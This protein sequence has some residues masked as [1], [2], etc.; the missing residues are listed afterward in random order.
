MTRQTKRGAVLGGR[1]CP[2]ATSTCCVHYTSL[3]NAGADGW[4]EKLVC[5]TVAK[6]YNITYCCFG[7]LAMTNSLY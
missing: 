6:A 7:S 5:G 4:F 1:E 3:V 2:A